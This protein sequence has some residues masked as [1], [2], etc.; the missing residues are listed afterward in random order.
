MTTTDACFA[1]SDRIWHLRRAMSEWSVDPEGGRARLLADFA[2]EFGVPKRMMTSVYMRTFKVERLRPDPCA[3]PDLDAYVAA[4]REE[5]IH[6][7][8]AHQADEAAYAQVRDR[9]RGRRPSKS[10]AYAIRAWR[11]MLARHWPTR[12]A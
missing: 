5:L 2:E 3:F 1:E 6:A 7:L 8:G 12:A 4:W 11:R 9:M 10:K